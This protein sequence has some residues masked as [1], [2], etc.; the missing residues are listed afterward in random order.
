MPS[1]AA[2]KTAFRTDELIPIRIVHGRAEVA[3]HMLDPTFV[4]DNIDAVRQRPGEPRSRR[5][6]RAPAARDARVAAAA[7]HSA[8]RGAEARAEHVGRPGGARQAAG[9]GREAP[10]RSEQGAQPE[11]QADGD[12]ARGRRAPARDPAGDA[13]EP[14]ARERAGRQERRPTTSSCARGASRGRSTSKPRRTGISGP[15]WASSTSSARRRS[16]GSRFAVLMGAGA[17]LERAL[18]NFML[19]AAHERARLH[20]GAAAVPRVVDDALRHRAAAEV[21]AGSVQDRRRVGSL[22]DPDRGSA[23]DEPVSRR[24][25]RRPSAADQATPRTRRVSAA[26]RAR[27]APTCAG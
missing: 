11:D 18:I 25:S 7:A 22:S 27:T 3:L 9:P 15:S 21:R 13:A 2:G 5:D 16:P 17:Q 4:R 1:P 23:G 12:R 20:R 24:D 6:D 8:D 10:L 26:K 14:A 19:D